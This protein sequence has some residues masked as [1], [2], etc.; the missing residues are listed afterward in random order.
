[1]VDRMGYNPDDVV[2]EGCLWQLDGQSSVWRQRWSVLGTLT[3]DVYAAASRP[4]LGSLAQKR[5]ILYEGALALPMSEAVMQGM[6]PVPTGPTGFLLK[7]DVDR[8]TQPVGVPPDA[9]PA[10]WLAA[11]QRQCKLASIA[12]QGELELSRDGRFFRRSP[13][14]EE[15]APAAAIEAIAAA[16]AAAP[17]MEGPMDAM[18]AAEAEAAAGG[19]MAG[20]P[21]GSDDPDLDEEVHPFSGQDVPGSEQPT[22]SG[23]GAGAEAAAAVAPEEEADDDSVA[24]PPEPA[25]ASSRRPASNL[26]RDDSS[27]P[28]PSPPDHASARP[29]SPGRS[30]GDVSSSSPSQSGVAPAVSVSSS[31]IQSFF[32]TEGTQSSS[33]RTPAKRLRSSMASGQSD[34]SGGSEGSKP[35]YASRGAQMSSLSRTPAGD[36]GSK[37]KAKFKQWSAVDEGMLKADAERMLALRTDN[38][39]LAGA[40]PARAYPHGNAAGQRGKY[41]GPDA[42]S[43]RQRELE[44]E[45]EARRL[46]VAA[47]VRGRDRRRSNSGSRSAAQATLPVVSEEAEPE[48]PGRRAQALVAP[49]RPGSPLA[50][51]RGESA[52]AGSASR[53]RPPGSVSSAVG[54]WGG[55]GDGASTVAESVPGVPTSITRVGPFGDSA[56]AP[57]P[58]PVGSPAFGQPRRAAKRL[59]REQAEKLREQVTANAAKAVNQAALATQQAEEAVRKLEGMGSGS[60]LDGPAGRLRGARKAGSL[61][62]AARGDDST[63][64]SPAPSPGGHDESQG[65]DADLDR[66][67]G[68]A[69]R[70]PA[71]REGP[72]PEPKAASATG[73]VAAAA[74]EAEEALRRGREAADSAIRAVA[75]AMGHS[76]RHSGEEP[77][78]SGEQGFSVSVPLKQQKSQ[79][80]A[81]AQAHSHARPTP[82]FG[83]RPAGQLASPSGG[84]GTGHALLSKDALDFE[85]PRTSEVLSAFRRAVFDSAGFLDIRRLP[86]LCRSLGLPV[87]SGFLGSQANVRDVDP[88]GEGAIDESEF[89]NWWGRHCDR[90]RRQHE[91]AAVEAAAQRHRN[92]ERARAQASMQDGEETV[93]GPLPEDD[94][95]SLASRSLDSKADGLQATIA[96]LARLQAQTA[97]LKARSQDLSVGRGASSPPG[98]AAG[99]A[100]AR[101]RFGA[102]TTSGE[103]PSKEATAAASSPE[104]ASLVSGRQ[105][106]LRRRAKRGDASAGVEIT[107]ASRPH[108]AAAADPGVQDAAAAAEAAAAEAATLSGFSWVRKYLPGPP[109]EGNNS[110]RAADAEA[111][112]GGEAGQDAAAPAAGAASG[113]SR[114]PADVSTLLEGARS[115]QADASSKAAAKPQPPQAAWPRVAGAGADGSG[116]DQGFTPGQ[117]ASGT[118]LSAMGALAVAASIASSGGGGAAAVAGHGHRLPFPGAEV[119]AR[120]SVL[121]PPGFGTRAADGIKAHGGTSQPGS[122][123]RRT[124]EAPRRSAVSAAGLDSAAAS[125]SPRAF[126]DLVGAA[127]AREETGTGRSGASEPHL[128]EDSP[129][130]IPLPPPATVVSCGAEGPTHG[131]LLEQARMAVSKRELGDGGV[132][133]EHGFGVELR[134]PEAARFGM[135]PVDQAA[136]MSSPGSALGAAT[137]V[138]ASQSRLAEVDLA[139][140]S[141]SVVSAPLADD[142][143][144]EAWQQTLEMPE[145]T[146]SQAARKA[147]AKAALLGRFARAAAKA[148]DTVVCELGLPVELRSIAPMAAADDDDDDD[149]DDNDDDDGSVGARDAQG[150]DRSPVG[151][152]FYHDGLILKVAE[153]PAG[154]GSDDDRSPAA[155]AR[156]GCN[157]SSVER[158]VMGNELR[159][160]R[161][162]HLA[163]TEVFRDW[164]QAKGPPGPGTEGRKRPPPLCTALCATVDVLGFRVYVL[165]VPPLDDEE[166]LV[167]GRVDDSQPM[168]DRSPILRRMMR[169]LAKHLNLRPHAAEALAYAPGAGEDPATLAPRQVQVPLSVT[170]VAHQCYDRRFYID[171]LATLMPAEAPA[172][173]V[174]TD[175]LQV[176]PNRLRPEL[177]AANSEPL[178]ADSFH[179]RGDESSPVA[180]DV[181]TLGAAAA[182]SDECDAAAT[183]AVR[184]LLSDRVSAVARALDSMQS[185]P[186]DSAEATLLLHQAGVNARYL[187]KVAAACVAPHAREALACEMVARTVKHVLNR[188]LRRKVRA[189]G[190]SAGMACKAASARATASG[191]AVGEA[192]EQGARAAAGVM[193]TLRG[194]ARQVIVDVFNLVLGAGDDCESFW[195][196][197]IL[198]GVYAKFGFRV[199]ADELEASPQA[200]STALALSSSSA[201]VA[202]SVASIDA[203]RGCPLHRPAL[204]AALQHHCGVLFRDGPAAAAATAAATAAAAAS[205]AGVPGAAGSSGGSAALSGS[206]ASY[207]SSRSERAAALAAQ[208]SA[209]MIL[210]NQLS[211]PAATTAPGASGQSL[212]Q[213]AVDAGEAAA[214]R[215]RQAFA[216]GL[217][218]EPLTPADIVFAP[219]CVSTLRRPGAALELDASAASA[220]EL[221][222]AGDAAGAVA[223]ANLRVALLQAMG[224]RAAESGP[225]PAWGS[226]G[227]GDALELGRALTLLAKAQL[228]SGHPAEALHSARL[229]LAAV[230]DRLQRHAEAAELVA[231]AL[232][233]LKLVKTELALGAVQRGTR[234]LLRL[235][236]ASAS[237]QVRAALQ[238][239]IR[240]RQRSGADSVGSSLRFVLGMLWAGP[241]PAYI[242]EVIEAVATGGRGSPASTPSSPARPSGRSGPASAFAPGAP[243]AADQLVCLVA[244][245]DDEAA[246]PHPATVSLL[247]ASASASLVAGEAALELAA[248]KAAAVGTE[249][250]VAFA[251]L[252]GGG[253]WSTSVAALAVANAPT[254]GAA[255]AGAAQTVSPTAMLEAAARPASQ[256]PQGSDLA[257]HAGAVSRLAHALSLD[258]AH[259]PSGVLGSADSLV[260]M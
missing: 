144:N 239:A 226:C 188:S 128:E 110:K 68:R 185:C 245:L 256:A 137:S 36:S 89:I 43:V 24:P 61:D 223:A 244:L 241:A 151:S 231:P 216:W 180:P 178:S 48:S 41:T 127:S 217:A 143:W 124:D 103:S 81:Q 255:A 62:D 186:L 140:T 55:G 52:G 248:A 197:I 253:A 77:P 165:A 49:A 73:S 60:P 74:A 33:D 155:F 237:A 184:R 243:P 251:R 101:G 108:D 193:G 228:A 202:Q 211:R 192:E 146:F 212:P 196:D 32:V 59:T 96:A 35:L 208:S 132:G 182:D 153:T 117:S 70:L 45:E 176:S 122:P 72:N 85:V 240:A 170:C 119:S 149:D 71:A 115:Q 249:G 247:P 27:E 138:A 22:P 98:N 139:A 163:A 46:L 12:A 104:G 118:A 204:F 169:R 159:G 87:P 100:G 9:K 174:A 250:S 150:A 53:P 189:V 113:A 236:F 187:G 19:R 21:S 83:G 121:A 168:L 257:R 183:R 201:A 125:L 227:G 141:Q 3:I 107:V 90:M 17:P 78:A 39:M 154:E 207:A 235:V 225:S 91:A 219:A 234:H 177:V 13:G 209:Q 30:P 112:G 93:R 82:A 120:S 145:W 175:G 105:R 34:E 199:A 160:Q 260:V 173:D 63:K 254:A 66:Q 246:S 194:E 258:F 111:A 162:V 26:A 172:A 69:A 224:S 131:S 179:P 80:A 47:Q 252:Q 67:R 233:S 218:A 167:F 147:T 42:R 57:S 38:T 56:A 136:G 75:A 161:I 1:M 4:P 229:Q 134:T 148:A 76:G 86:E 99:T 50:F 31:G 65:G 18:A 135:G 95:E 200:G 92:A 210:C 11:V 37:P 15:V 20:L 28:P 230:M 166:T 14:G 2:M 203:A 129:V 79:A 23:A 215:A 64:A 191:V 152:A 190:R 7:L 54:V 259:L 232:E 40:S 25:P 6:P 156:A 29:R 102:W 157:A 213:V 123:A 5:W 10:A 238:G 142:H 109:A 221:L 205:G 198:P 84:R 181:L 8:V 171:N 58:A 94:D 97:A 195:R 126:G 88:T 106:P 133:L 114:K 44:A 130:L 214:A 222:A 220:E 51:D 206:R 158:R 242:R 116:V 16:G 164:L